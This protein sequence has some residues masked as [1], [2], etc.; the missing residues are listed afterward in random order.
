M[1][2]VDWVRPSESDATSARRADAIVLWCLLMASAI[3]GLAVLWGA[4]TIVFGPLPPAIWVGVA[5]LECLVCLFLAGAL[6]QE[7]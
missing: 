4:I 2:S 7:K 3:L 1:V 5:V 6:A